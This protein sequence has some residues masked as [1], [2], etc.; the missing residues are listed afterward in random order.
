MRLLFQV[1]LSSHIQYQKGC[2]S[3]GHE[4]SFAPAQKTPELGDR[5][6]PALPRASLT[7]N[8]PRWPDK[9]EGLITLKKN[10]LLFSFFLPLK[11]FHTPFCRAQVNFYGPPHNPNPTQR[12]PRTLS[13]GFHSDLPLW[14]DLKSCNFPRRFLEGLFFPATTVRGWHRKGLKPSCQTTNSGTGPEG[15]WEPEQ[16]VI[17]AGL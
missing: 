15:T 12:A 10:S 7:H 5:R 13:P 3:G 11:S 4:C 14:R 1:W 16:P 6:H 8:R 17:K 2:L 9:W